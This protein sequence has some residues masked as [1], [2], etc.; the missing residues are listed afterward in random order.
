[1]TETTFDNVL[2]DIQF[3]GQLTGR[4]EQATAITS[5]MRKRYAEITTKVASATTKPRV[6]WEL[7]A[8]D[9]AKPYTVG[10]G[11]FVHD[12]I[13]LGGGTNIFAD[14]GSAYPQVGLEQVVA[15]DPEVIILSDAAYGITVESVGQRPG[16][17][18]VAAVKQ[19]RVH[20]IDDDLVSRPGPRLIDGLEAAAKLIHPELFK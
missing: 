18:G 12:L 13:G 4:F 6:Y 11:S 8:T 7:D 10:P 9:A 2:A 15:A 1:V 5:S 16:M 20:P 17:S 19:Q 3:V 14:V